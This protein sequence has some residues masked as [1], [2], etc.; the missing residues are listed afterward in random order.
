MSRSDFRFC[1]NFLTDEPAQEIAGWWQ[2]CEAAGIDYVGVAD[3]PMIARETFVT[4]AYGAARTSRLGLMTAITNPV[5]RDPSVMASS[6]FTLNEIAPGRIVCGIGT[7]DSAVWSVG[8][9]PARVARLGAYVTALR[10]LLRGE[11]AEFEGRRFA[12]AWKRW[13]PPSPVPVYVACSGPRVL[14]LGAQLADGLVIFMGFSPESIAYANRIIDEACAEVGRDRAELDIW[15]QTT[16][17]FAP[18]VE[19]ALE[20]SLGVNTSWMTMGSVEGKLIPEELIGPLK[21]FN[22]DMESVTASYGAGDR[23]RVLVARAKEMGLYDWLISMAPG[24]WGPPDNV[25]ARLREFGAQGLTNWQF[26]V[27][28][29]HGDR[30]AYIDKFVN[31]VLPA[32]GDGGS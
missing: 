31:G 18:T 11:E 25:A 6:L 7:G 9:Q 13:T 28:Q 17:N 3:S 4:A 23:G 22:A 8:L 16:I 15:W 26:Y 20:W 32:L 30:Y 12:P 29:F 2:A 24:F 19:E 10:T 27:A 14:R 21:R 1:L 5:S